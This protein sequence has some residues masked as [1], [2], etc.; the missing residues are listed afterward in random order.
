MD[1]FETDQGNKKPVGGIA[2]FRKLS[3]KTPA[4]STDSGPWSKL[5]DTCKA[6]AFKVKEGKIESLIFLTDIKL[7][8]VHDLVYKWSNMGYPQTDFVRAPGYD[9]EGNQVGD[10]II[11]LVKNSPPK[12][13]GV[14]TVLTSQPVEKNGEVISKYTICP[15]MLKDST[16]LDILD[17]TTAEHGKDLKFA[18]FRVQ[19]SQKGKKS[20]NT[21]DIW[22]YKKHVTPQQLSDTAPDWKEK[23]AQ[24]DLDARFAVLDKDHIIR[25]LGL[26][27]HVADK[28]EAKKSTHSI[29]R[30]NKE[31]WL[32]LSGK[33]KEVMPANKN[34]EVEADDDNVFEDDS[35]GF[36]ALSDLDM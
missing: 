9:E 16:I 25:L 36:D 10:D 1:I 15:L 20:S 34:L 18:Q 23:A 17:L 29:L 5:W 27:V 24:I 7:V 6:F 2:A 12:T 30:Y 28:N 4:A 3:L 13:I 19:R 33:G 22:T 31:A 11:G 35:D 32:E 26:H 14:A 21:G 8:I